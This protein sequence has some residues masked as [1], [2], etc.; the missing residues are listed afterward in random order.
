M[1]KLPTNFIH[2]IIRLCIQSKR[3][4]EICV[5]HFHYQYIPDELPELK[6]ILKT[7][8]TYY[9]AN[10]KIPSFDVRRWAFG[11]RCSLFP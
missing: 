11:V 6:K 9:K 7:I 1:Q 2:E 3:V 4:C 5:E 8:S 10:D